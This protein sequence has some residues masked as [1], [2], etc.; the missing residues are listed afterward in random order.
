MSERGWRFWSLAGEGGKSAVSS[1][2][3]VAAGAGRPG[4]GGNVVLVVTAG[5]V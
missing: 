2:V 4:D 5:A 3:S 1:R